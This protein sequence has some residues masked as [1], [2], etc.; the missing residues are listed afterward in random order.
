[1]NLLAEGE[2]GYERKPRSCR[3]VILSEW[4]LGL[5]WLQA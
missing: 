1:M 2:C 3:M 5:E 4:P